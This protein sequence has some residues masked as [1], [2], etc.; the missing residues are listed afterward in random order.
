MMSLPWFLTRQEEIM[1]IRPRYIMTAAAALTLLALPQAC[2]GTDP[3]TAGKSGLIEG[4]NRFGF[5]LLARETA[6]AGSENVF[7]SPVSVALCLGMAYNGAAGETASEMAGLLGAGDMSVEDFSAE[8]GSLAAGLSETGSGIKLSIANSL[9]LREGFPF[10]E[11]F[12][13]RNEKDFDAGVFRLQSAKEINRW[14]SDR[15]SGMIGRIIDSVREDDIAI[16]VNAI[17]FKGTWTV[18]FDREMTSERPFHAPDGEKKVPMMI[19]TGR[20]LCGENDLFQSVRMTYGESAE[21][22]DGGGSSM[23]ILLPAEGK[24][25]AD[26]TAMLDPP[27][28]KEW[29]SGMSR[30]EV[31]V[32]LPRFRA[33]FFSRLN[34]TL[35]A[36]GMKEAFGAGADFSNLCKCSPGDVFISDV[37]HK[38]V[39]EVDEKGTEAAAAT[40][41]T[42]RLTSAV[43]AEPFR[44]VV[45]RPFI[46]AITDDDTGLI[47][48]AGAIYDPEIIE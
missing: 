7:L 4:Y 6:G 45:D 20:L 42:I 47:L 25:V 40:A 27:K 3:G 35:M 31:T 36:M 22:S 29:I 32:E 14:V 18:E 12:I 2:A 44:I 39:I 15:T 38:A 28:W 30:R 19:R 10:R 1:H 43:P 8:N 5:R 23:Y 26:I 11:G 24:T 34:G 46:L 13:K 17:Y 9:W 16:L 21:G 37:L 33:E 48:F 41:I